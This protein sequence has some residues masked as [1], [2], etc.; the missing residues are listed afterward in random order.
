MFLCDKE[1]SP[2]RVCALQN[3]QTLKI[4]LKEM[5][6]LDRFEHIFARFALPGLIRY[7]VALNALVFI[8]LKLNPGYAQL[9]VLDR[10]AILQGEVWRLISWIFLP[11]TMSWILIFFYLSFI[12]WLG[13]L[14]EGT[15]G[16]FRLNVFYILGVVFC[17]ASE[18]IL[19]VS[20]GNAF[21]LL[22]LLFAVATLAPDLEILFL[23]I[24]PLKLKWL[25]LISLLLP[26]LV[27]IFG[28]IELKAA[29]V[30]CL[31]N[32]WVFFGPSIMR[33][34]YFNKKARDRRA[35]FEASKMP[36]EE[37]I[38][39]CDVCGVTEKTNPE[40]EFRVAANGREYCTPHLPR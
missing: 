20:G 28:A 31:G 10:T 17:D 8:L 29:V 37:S 33:T 11:G 38:H 3:H 19:G 36:V 12:W 18:F 23:Y 2:K 39:R 16:T 15:W 14:L 4:L 40:M 32:Y 13:D 1:H 26:I 27:L 5:S 35:R 25:A 9:L 22:S 24:L 30:L 6:I 34:M 21:L 7:V